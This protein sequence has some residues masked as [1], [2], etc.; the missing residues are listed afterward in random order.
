MYGWS[1]RSPSL[2]LIWN[3]I[4]VPDSGLSLQRRDCAPNPKATRGR[5]H[6][7]LILTQVEAV[8]CISRTL[9]AQALTSGVLSQATILYLHDMRQLSSTA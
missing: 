6:I 4:I 1:T 8:G 3:L 9:N 5:E 2:H 7:P